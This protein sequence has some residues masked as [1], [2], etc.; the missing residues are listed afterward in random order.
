[1]NSLLNP[2]SIAVIGASRFKKKVGYIV[3]NNLINSKLKV[4]PVN[5]KARSIKGNK[6][7]SNI[8]EVKESI[9]CA[10]V[11]IPAQ[12]VPSVIKDCAVKG[13]GSVI[14]ISAGFKEA[15]NAKLEEEVIKQAG[16]MRVL[17]P[18]VLGIIKPGYFNASFFEGMPRKGGISFISQSGA[19]G[20]ALLDS[21]I[22]E[23]LGLRYFISIGN[24][25]DVD[26]DDLINELN[27][28]PET[29]VI[30]LYAESL[31]DGPS[32]MKACWESKKPIIVLKAG[33]SVEG[34]R[35]TSSHTGSL[36]GSSEVYEA[37]FKQAGVRSASTLTSLINSALLA[38]KFSLTGKRVLI[39]TNAG[40][41]SI[42]MTDACVGNK[43]EVPKLPDSVKDKLSKA[44]PPVWSHN[45]PIDVVGDALADRYK[46]VFDVISKESFYDT[47]IVMLTPQAM[48]EVKETAQAVI[49]LHKITGK[50]VIP[51]FLG[52]AKIEEGLKLFKKEGMPVFIDINEL[53]DALSIIS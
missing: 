38:D 36:A 14:I 48:T 21:A 9:D 19:L 27:N 25:A 34:R 2:K 23:G 8:N 39:I 31:K 52:G 46:N 12:L 35:A 51:C 1:M 10:V 26:F 22:K 49:N 29:S 6:V 28:D 11:C 33:K 17:G 42:L 18:N 13:V 43:L 3:Y 20:V 41:P 15:G 30:V 24:M 5:P 40:G 47:I 44:L 7:Y 4:Y 16:K 32:F 53:A 50:P 45:N 37:A